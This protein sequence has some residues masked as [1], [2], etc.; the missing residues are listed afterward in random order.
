MLTMTSLHISGYEVVFC[1]VV[2]S[3]INDL[4]SSPSYKVIQVGQEGESETT[5]T[6]YRAINSKT[7]A[8][9]VISEITTADLVTCSVGPNILKMIAPV[10]AKGID[11]RPNDAT[12]IAVIACE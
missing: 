3:L 7:N 9:D 6:N 11:A 4:K 2:E 12:Q 10:I 1:D 8:A 5:I